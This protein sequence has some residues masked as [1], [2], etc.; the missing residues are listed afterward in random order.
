MGGGLRSDVGTS[1]VFSNLSDSAVLSPGAGAV[2]DGPSSPRGAVRGRSVCGRTSE[3]GGGGGGLSP[4]RPIRPPRSGAVRGWRCRSPTRVWRRRRRRRAKRRARSW[5]RARAGGGRSAAS[6]WGGREQPPGAGGAAGSA[7]GRCGSG[8]AGCRGRGGGEGAGSA[9]WGA[10]LGVPRCGVRRAGGSG[11]GRPGARRSAS[12]RGGSAVSAGESRRGTAVAEDPVRPLRRSALGRRSPSS[13][14]GPRRA[15]TRCPPASRGAPGRPQAPFPQRCPRIRAMC[16]GSG[17]RIRPCPHRG[18]RERR[19]SRGKSSPRAEVGQRSQKR[20]QPTLIP[21]VRPANGPVR[22][23][24]L[25][26][27]L[28]CLW[29]SLVRSQRSENHKGWTRSPRPPSNPSPPTHHHRA[30][31]PCP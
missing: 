24:A 6:R 11:A 16:P 13:R 2:R 19:R 30:H 7:G 20:A 26:P 1:E 22:L 3:G 4:I 25:C 10:G 14:A 21:S 12:R 29:A 23:R 27:A 5:R 17:A 28:P 9:R 15:L 31:R 18:T 8:P